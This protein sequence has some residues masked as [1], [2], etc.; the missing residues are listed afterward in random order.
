MTL[1]E[2]ETWLFIQSSLVGT[3][4]DAEAAVG[5]L[6]AAAT[7]TAFDVAMASGWLPEHPTN[8]RHAPNATAT[9]AA[10]LWPLIV[11]LFWSAGITYKSIITLQYLIIF[12]HEKSRT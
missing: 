3:A 4:T 1:V 5:V 12:V 11:L 7:G 9:T 10:L 8:A 2:P 6:V